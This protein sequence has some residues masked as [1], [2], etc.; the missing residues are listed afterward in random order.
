[1]HHQHRPHH[2]HHHHNDAGERQNRPSPVQGRHHLQ[3]QLVSSYIHNYSRAF[4]HKSCILDH[5]LI[6]GPDWLRRWS[7]PRPDHD[8]RARAPPHLLHAS[9]LRALLPL[10]LHRL[11][12]HVLPHQPRR[13]QGSVQRADHQPDRDD[14]HE[15]RHPPSDP[16]DILSHLR[17]HLAPGLL[18]LPLHLHRR[19]GALHLDPREQD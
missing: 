4:Y 14:H 9:T 18:R 11:D 17:R 19:A 8:D 16:Q 7:L 13:H 10:R 3:R 15:Q 6:Q 5:W 2:H 1:M 12:H